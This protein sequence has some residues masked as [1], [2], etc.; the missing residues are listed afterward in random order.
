VENT[1]TIGSPQA[2]AAAVV[3]GLVGHVEVLGGED[4]DGPRVR[5]GG[6]G[7]NPEVGYLALTASSS[8]C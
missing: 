7:K 4:D 3:E 8:P 1:R 5:T 2:P 6:G